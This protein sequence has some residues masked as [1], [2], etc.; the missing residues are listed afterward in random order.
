LW[1]TSTVPSVSGHRVL[2]ALLDQWPIYLAYLVSFASIGTAWISHT[3]L[4]D[5]LAGGPAAS[6]GAHGP[7]SGSVALGGRPVFAIVRAHRFGEDADFRPG[8]A[9]E[10]PSSQHHVVQLAVFADNANTVACVLDVAAGKL[11]L[12]R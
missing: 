3:T 9:T 6:D 8:F 11:R 7:G 5:M 4:A 2:S 10:L 1:W 12:L